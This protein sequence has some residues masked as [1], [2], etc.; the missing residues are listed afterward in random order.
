MLRG[1]NSSL[2]LY[3]NYKMFFIRQKDV[4]I[5]ICEDRVRRGKIVGEQFTLHTTANTRQFGHKL[6]IHFFILLKETCSFDLAFGCHKNANH[7]VNIV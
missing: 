2:A 3:T 7:I 5:C 1:G 6:D 4:Q